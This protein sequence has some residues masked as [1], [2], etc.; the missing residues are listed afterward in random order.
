MFRERSSRTDG[1]VVDNIQKSIFAVLG[2][3]AFATLIIPSGDSF[4]PP[5]EAVN[6]AQSE[7]AE[8]LA[9][10]ADS[11][12]PDEAGEAPDEFAS[13]DGELEA[14]D[15]VANFGQPMMDATPLGDSNNF[16]SNESPQANLPAGA[17]DNVP[18]AYAAAPSAQYAG[19]V[20]NAPIVTNQPVE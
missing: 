7:S 16:S 18:P 4:A 14:P 1:A 20:T 11:P 13:Q 19:S 5:K 9:P 3:S 17:L 6:P 8:I 15:E 12:S 2:V 10:A